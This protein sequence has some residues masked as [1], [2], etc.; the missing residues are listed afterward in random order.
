MVVQTQKFFKKF[1]ANVTTRGGSLSTPDPVGRA[2]DIVD[3]APLGTGG[4]SVVFRGQLIYKRLNEEAYRELYLPVLTHEKLRNMKDWKTACDAAFAEV[5]EMSGTAVEDRV[6]NFLERVGRFGKKREVAVRISHLPMDINQRD[7]RQDFITGLFHENLT[8]QFARGRLRT[9]Q[10]FSLVELLGS[11]LKPE[12]TCRWGMD[13]HFQVAEGLV[14]GLKRFGDRIGVH[15]DVK[16]SNIFFT[17]SPQRKPKR[18]AQ[19]KLA[20][21]GIMRPENITLSFQTLEGSTVGTPH[22]MSPEQANDST[23]VSALTDQFSAGA[24]LYHLITARL[25]LGVKDTSRHDA[26]RLARERPHKPRG[27]AD[28]RDIR[29]EGL[30]QIVARMMQTDPGRRYPRFDMILE[31]LDRVKRGKHPAHA[32][33]VHVRKAMMPAKFSTWHRRRRRLRI[34]VILLIAATAAVAGFLYPDVVS[35]LYSFL[36]GLFRYFES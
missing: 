15:R 26:L 36:I 18:L 21:F 11:E 29:L 33:G 25:P 32:S 14:R 24:S 34:A 28:Q 3:D 27:F 8:Y 23:K 12:Q 9:G 13:L 1:C 6:K 5:T 4:E 17:G 7:P 35:S 19:I 20:D 30:E 2:V 10:A 16:P 31:D 22:Y